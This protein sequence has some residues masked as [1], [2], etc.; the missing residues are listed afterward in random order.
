MENTSLTKAQQMLE[1]MLVSMA[2]QEAINQK[3]LKRITAEQKKAIDTVI[4]EMANTF[5]PAE[6]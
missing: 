5:N 2:I 3:A 1:G 6:A 4:A